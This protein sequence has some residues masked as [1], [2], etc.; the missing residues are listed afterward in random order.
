MS[1]MCEICKLWGVEVDED[2]YLW[3]SRKGKPYA[4]VKET[5]CKK[6]DDV[7]LQALRD[8]IYSCGECESKIFED[9]HGIT[10]IGG[11]EEVE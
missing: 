9:A 4:P 5:W 1:K 11:E 10:T 6:C 2:G 3:K 7:T 8:G